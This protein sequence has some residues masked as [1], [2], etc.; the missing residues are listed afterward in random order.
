[1]SYLNEECGVDDL[2]LPIPKR[3]PSEMSQSND[4]SLYKSIVGEM[5]D[6]FVAKNNDYGNS[7][8]DAVSE[9][10]IIAGITPIMFKFNR[11]KNLIKGQE[12]MVK[13][14]SIED[15]LMDMANY[16]ILLMME[17]KKSVH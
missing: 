15:T 2:I 3:N 4:T 7:F 13:S 11:L 10:G 5:T 14:E 8:A 12:S 17:L 1:M 6:I 16:C 9:L